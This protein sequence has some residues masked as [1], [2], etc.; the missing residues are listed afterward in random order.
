MLL[1]SILPA[2]ALSN[3]AISACAKGPK[4][5]ISIASVA[6]NVSSNRL[7]AVVLYNADISAG[8][9]PSCT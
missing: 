3:D 7:P 5:P 2:V 6:G 9:A 8:V 1:Y 4:Y